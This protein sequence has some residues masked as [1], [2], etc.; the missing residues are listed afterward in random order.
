[1]TAVLSR[2]DQAV[3]LNWATSLIQRFEGCRYYAYQ[4]I[5]GIWTIGWG[6]VLTPAGR[7][8]RAGDSVT[9][10]QADNMLAGTVQRVLAAVL[11][12][13][14]DQTW[15]PDEVAALTSFTYNV[16]TGAFNRSTLARYLDV[17]Q[18]KAAADEFL[19]W[20]IAGNK[21]S[22]GLLTRRLL[23]KAVFE[24]H[25]SQVVGTVGPTT[26]VSRS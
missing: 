4:D 22:P 13:L 10:A 21:K 14:P 5:R 17:G 18:V 6:S 8:V 26:G 2:A 20:C 7:P 12:R 24:G 15:F 19:L 25:L 16:G 23:E 1:M 9:A 3:A 11:S